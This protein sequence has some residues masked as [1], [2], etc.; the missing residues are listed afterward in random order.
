[1]CIRDSPK[2]DEYYAE[3]DKR[4]RLEFPQKFDKRE[5]QTSKPTQNVASVNRSTTRQGRK[6]VRLTSSQVA[7]AKKLGVPLEEYAKQIKL[8]EGA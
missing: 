6:V 3:V 4:I 1:M 7:I 5:T 2:S 8:T